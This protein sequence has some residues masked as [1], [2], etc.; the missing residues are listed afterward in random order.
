MKGFRPPAWTGRT[1]A[2]IGAGP[3]LTAADCN[4]VAAAGLP[5]IAVNLAFRLAPGAEILLGYD[6]A[7]W[8]LYWREA[9]EMCPQAKRLQISQSI[10]GVNVESVWGAEWVTNGYNSGAQALALALAAGAARVLLL[11]IDCKG[12]P[13]KM[14]FH[15][16]HVAGLKNAKSMHLWPQAFQTVG[17][18]AGKTGAS[19][20]NCSRDTALTCFPRSPL[21]EELAKL[22]KLENCPIEG[23]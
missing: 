7:F 17:R 3:S 14:H 20:V 11:G 23:A 12:T 2:V 21:E 22:R 10:H 9:A 4:A 16:D 13:G 6:S 19:I 15:G 1:V 8:K 5:T 18:A